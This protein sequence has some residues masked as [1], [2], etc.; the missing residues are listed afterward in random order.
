M[1]RLELRF[2]GVEQ[3]LVLLD[4]FNTIIIGF[5]LLAIVYD[6]LNKKNR[7]YKEVRAN[8][9][10][11]IGNIVLNATIFT[12]IF[13]LTL[14]FAENF[15]FWNIPM[16]A[17]SWV[18]VLLVADFS[19]YWMHRIEHKVR[20]LWALHSVHHSSQEFDLTTSLRLAWFEGFIEWIF[21]VPMIL[22]GFDLVQVIVAISVVIAYQTWI[23]TEHIGKLGLFDQLF[24][25]PSVHRVH[26]GS[27]PKYIDKNF[28]GILMI[29][30]KIFKTYQAEEEKVIYGLMQNIKTSNPISINFYEWKEMFRDMS[31]SKSISKKIQW[32][33][34]PPGWRD[35]EVK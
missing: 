22:I 12:F 32:M 24:N 31:K 19:Y 23:H 18:V 28:G 29:W 33:L 5:A 16:N 3:W 35:L 20:F 34:N 25:T 14:Y 2:V 4:V 8:I 10:I 27:N 7:G 9:L 30:D 1:E 6:F 26:H 21:F 17:Y 15:A 11:G 13:V